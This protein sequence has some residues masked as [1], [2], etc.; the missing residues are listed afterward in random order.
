MSRTI[1]RRTADRGTSAPDGRM[2]AAAVLDT[3]AVVV[4]VAVGRRTHDQDPG[5]AAVF[6]TAAPFLI[7][8]FAGWLVA[9]AW[10][11]PLSLVT[12]LVVW[13]VTIV[14]G[15]LLRNL[16]FGDGTA[17]SF[18]VV[19]AAFTFACLIGWRLVALAV[20]RV[21]QRPTH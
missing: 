17:T 1:E 20:E 5:T 16:V 2:T 19:A 14:G 12:G 7:A 11:R 21:R 3:V 8:L 6:A 15:M 18:V 4:F 13:A 10:R 9:R